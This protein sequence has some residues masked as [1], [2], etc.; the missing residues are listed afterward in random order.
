MGAVH[1]AR[2]RSLD[3]DD[4]LEK[5]IRGGLRESAVLI[6]VG[7]ETI[8]SRQW[9]RDEMSWYLIGASLEQVSIQ[10]M[11]GVFFPFSDVERLP[12]WAKHL[13]DPYPVVLD[14]ERQELL[15]EQD[16]TTHGD[17]GNN[18]MGGSRVYLMG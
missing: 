16:L 7:S 5:Q 15:A 17:Y 11:Y 9:C 8:E 10:R 12:R 14:P 2:E 3:A 18:F 1:L 6:V 4:D 13:P